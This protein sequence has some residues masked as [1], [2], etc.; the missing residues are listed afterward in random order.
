MLG[1]TTTTTKSEKTKKKGVCRAGEERERE[2]WIGS[3]HNVYV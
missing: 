1:T 3:Q 2:E